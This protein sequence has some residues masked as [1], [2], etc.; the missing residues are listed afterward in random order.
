MVCQEAELPEASVASPSMF[1][2]KT[3]KNNID[4]ST[5]GIR[6][7]KH[8]QARGSRR[9]KKGEKPFFPAIFIP[10]MMIMATEQEVKIGCAQLNEACCIEAVPA[11]LFHPWNPS[12]DL[13]IVNFAAATEREKEPNDGGWQH[14]GSQG[15][16]RDQ[17]H[18]R[19]P[20]SES[21]AK[22]IL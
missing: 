2:K 6:H 8:T 22:Q 16:R 3:N 21:R 20:S 9:E 10:T 17:S 1:V 4:V 12:F 13:Q 15:R 14:G 11:G 18:Q 19:Q 5:Q 7:E